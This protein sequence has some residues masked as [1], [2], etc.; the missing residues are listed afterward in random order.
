M[1][2][3]DFRRLPLIAWAISS[4]W[5]GKEEACVHICLCLRS[6]NETRMSLV[7]YGGAYRGAKRLPGQQARWSHKSRDRVTWVT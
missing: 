6:F 3:K 4:L 5:L 7:A 1:E 2:D